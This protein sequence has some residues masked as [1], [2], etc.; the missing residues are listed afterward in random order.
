MLHSEIN[1]VEHRMCDVVVDKGWLR[2]TLF[3][4]AVLVDKG[5]VTLTLVRMAEA[6]L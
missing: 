1:G 5:R 4:I 6:P 2:A 3:W